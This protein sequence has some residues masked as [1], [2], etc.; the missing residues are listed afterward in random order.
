MFVQTTI[1][2]LSKGNPELGVKLY[3][4][5]ALAADATYCS[6]E[7]SGPDDG[8]QQIVSELFAQAFQLHEEEIDGTVAQQRCI[9]NM[10][11]A[12]LACQSLQSGDYEAFI[13]KA[14]QYAAKLMKKQNQ[15]QMV[16][17][18]SHLFYAAD[19][20]VR[21]VGVSYSTNC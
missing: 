14:A 5:T 7:D 15:C 16:A 4:H 18:C 8:F 12:L 21:T 1:S 13:T 11:G 2:L 20:V 3:L 17:L 10:I 6:Q 9:V 19:H